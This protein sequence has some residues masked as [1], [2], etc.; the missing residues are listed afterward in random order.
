MLTAPHVVA[1][2]IAAELPVQQRLHDVAV[3]RERLAGA[4]LPNP[5]LMGCRFA[6]LPTVEEHRIARA[7]RLTAHDAGES[8]ELAIAKRRE[9]Q[10]QLDV[11]I[12]KE[13]RFWLYWGIM[14]FVI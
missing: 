1:A 9:E 13:V 14:G 7:E 11:S 12:A 6:F 3:E 10:R 5:Q 4:G 8:A 2:L